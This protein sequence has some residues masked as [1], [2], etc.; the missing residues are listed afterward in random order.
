VAMAQS[1][2]GRSP[3]A[4]ADL[5]SRP[6]N[7]RAAR[8]A[9]DMA[10]HLAP[11]RWWRSAADHPSRPASERPARPASGSDRAAPSTRGT[12]A[13]RP[14]SARAGIAFSRRFDRGAFLLGFAAS[15]F[16]DGILLH[17]VL[18]WHHLLSAIQVG[19][20]R[21]LLFQV[22]A[23]GLF[24]A[25]MYLIALAGIW[26]LWLA[27]RDAATPGSGRRLLAGFWVGFGAWH[28]L[29]AVLSHWVAGIHRIRMDSA[30]PLAWDLAWLFLFGILPLLAGWRMRQGGGGPKAPLG[31]GG[32]GAAMGLAALTVTGAVFHLFPLRA[33][34]ADTV[35]VALRPDV[36]ATA[37]FRALEHTDTRVLWADGAGGVWLLANAPPPCASSCTG[38]GPCTSARRWR[39]PAAPPG[40]ATVPLRRPPAADP[41]RR[42]A[43][44]VKF[45][46]GRR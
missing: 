15:G 4:T 16:F 31:A 41:D 35:V 18:Q 8:P 17:Q 23:D 11:A 39:P 20:A 26:L 36:P 9:A 1:A 32:A 12:G 29:D 43:A 30:N 28:V 5:S 13:A 7:V 19:P 27:R 24:H 45:L 3:G 37:L 33:A 42:A 40:R 44:G 38:T 25:L 22:M 6:A 2:A 14:P 21:D 10:P 34:A 46:H